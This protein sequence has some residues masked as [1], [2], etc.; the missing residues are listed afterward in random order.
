[1]KKLSLLVIVMGSMVVTGCGKS[2]EVSGMPGGEQIPQKIEQADALMTAVEPTIT[3]SDEDCT[4][5]SC[6]VSAIFTNQGGKV[7]NDISYAFSVDSDAING[8]MSS[9]YA[10]TVETAQ[11]TKVTYTLYYSGTLPNGKLGSVI[12]NYAKNAAGERE[13]VS[14]EV[15]KQ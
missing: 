3:I 8:A 9:T 12:M 11:T 1:M 5:G 15:F 2:I 6:R 7:A 10:D 13:K 14:V 4:E